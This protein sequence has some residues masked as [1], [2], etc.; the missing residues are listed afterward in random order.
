MAQDTSANQKTPSKW[1]VTLLSIAVAILVLVANSALWFNGYVFDQGN[2]TRL[3]TQ[4]IQQES[5]RQA[6]AT[7]L[8]NRLLANRPLLTRL[9]QQPA[10][11]VISG[12][13]GS[14]LAEQVFG[15]VIGGL[16]SIATSPNPQD[17]TLDLSTFKQIAARIVQ[18][19]GTQPNEPAVT[20]QDIPNTITI[21][22]ANKVPNIYNLGVALLWIGPAALIAAIALLIYLLVSSRK[23]LRQLAYT[24]GVLAAAVVGV[25]LLAMAI[26]PILEPMVLSGVQNGQMRVVAQN[27]YGAF[28]DAFNGQTSWLFWVGGLLFLLAILIRAYP[29]IGEWLSRHF[30]RT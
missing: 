30:K 4:A 1:L 25:G 23:G 18:I 6:I 5:S 10:V 26:G 11:S 3:T 27:I 16:Q 28:V 20:D 14:N 2:F 19:F 21:V 8:T 7:E 24:L 12:A 13:L 22:D 29:A 9:A 17:V 15:R